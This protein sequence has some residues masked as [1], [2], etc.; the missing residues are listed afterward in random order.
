[1]TIEI[2]KDTLEVG[3]IENLLVFSR[4]EKES[5]AANIVNE[6]RNA[7]SMVVK[8]GDKGVGEKLPVREGSDPE[9]VFD[10]SGSFFEVERG[11]GETDGDA[12]ALDM[13]DA[14][15]PFQID[16]L[17]TRMTQPRPKLRPAERR[18]ADVVLNDI[19]AAMKIVAGTARSMGF[20]VEG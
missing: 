12:L 18:V 9:M 2:K 16:D 4:A 3:F 13:P 17:I 5:G 20:T 6:T 8:G 19:E 14:D 10:V 7:L 1:M 11:Q 15:G